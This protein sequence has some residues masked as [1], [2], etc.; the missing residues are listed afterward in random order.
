MAH[1][2]LNVDVGQEMHLDFDETAALAIFAATAFDIETETAG[3][4]ATY[5]GG[6]QLSKEFADRRECPRVSDRI[7]A[8]RA[9]NGALVDHDRL[10]NLFDATQAAER[11]R[12]F[13]GIVEMA[14]QCP[15]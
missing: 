13:L 2:A 6:R 15:S 9:P 10:I 3:I 14:E 8:W 4:V 5:T 1:F 11:S 12:F 7:R